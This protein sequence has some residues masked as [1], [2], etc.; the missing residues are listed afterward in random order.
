MH[1][2]SSSQQPSLNQDPFLPRSWEL[3]SEIPVNNNVRTRT[4][5]S[6]L[7]GFSLMQ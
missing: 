7:Q 2:Q 3:L 6:F 4:P 5:L 1:N